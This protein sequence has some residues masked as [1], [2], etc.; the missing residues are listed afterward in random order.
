M[1]FHLWNLAFNQSRSERGDSFSLFYF[2]GLLQAQAL[3]SSQDNP[4]SF[5]CLAK[6]STL[7]FVL[8]ISRMSC[9]DEILTITKFCVLPLISQIS[10]YFLGGNSFDHT[11]AKN[12]KTFLS[13]ICTSWLCS[14][15]SILLK[16]F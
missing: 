3:G 9:N 10:T 11:T 12:L 14:M 2:H 5:S 1:S 13:P 6:R 15:N 16:S 4:N 7:T 8:I